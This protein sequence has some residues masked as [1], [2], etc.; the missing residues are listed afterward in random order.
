MESPLPL[1]QVGRTSQGTGQSHMQREQC[2][3]M[4]TFLDIPSGTGRWFPG[5]GQRGAGEGEDEPHH[6]PSGLTS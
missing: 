1:S 3:W 6:L 2:S 4:V 5:F